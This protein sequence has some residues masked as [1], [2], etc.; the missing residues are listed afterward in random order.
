MNKEFGQWRQAFAKGIAVIVSVMTLLVLSGCYSD[1][2]T[3]NY[4]EFPDIADLKSDIIDDHGVTKGEQEVNME[5][6][7]E[8]NERELDPYTINA[9]DTIK[10]IVYNHPDLTSQMVVTPDGY[11][12]MVFLGQV[13]VAGKTLAQAAKNIEELLEEFIRSPVVGISPVEIHSETVTIS[14][15]CAK[16]GMYTISNS[17]RLADLYAQAGGSSTRY[18]DGQVLDAADLVNSYFMRDGTRL[19][20]DFSKA[21]EEGDMNNNLL[22]RKGDYIYIAVRS[23]SM[24][25]LIGDVGRPHKRIWDKNLGILE[26]LTTG[27]GLRETHW[28]HAIIIRGG[29]D[30][31]TLYRVDIDGILR[32][33][34]PNVFLQSGDFVYVPHD[35]ASEYNV[36][37][38]KILP[39]GQ[40]MNTLIS[41]YRVYDTYH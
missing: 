23:E 29:T 15:A 31:P 3:G 37:V 41:P 6:L 26:L 35:N 19:P 17:M 24:V 34:K 21:I 22:L 16:P 10:I 7:I 39:T 18:Y 33:T 28:S 13:Q 32:G 11:I 5:K 36:F 8:Q 14:G 30:N 12:G 38:R 40:L 2:M 1:R 25:C 9:G 4:M 27:G 20:V